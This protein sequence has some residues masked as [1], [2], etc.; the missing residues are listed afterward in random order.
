LCPEIHSMSKEAING[1]VCSTEIIHSAVH[2]PI[3]TVTILYTLCP[4]SSISR[5]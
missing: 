1:D 4:I 5:T 2:L 3:T